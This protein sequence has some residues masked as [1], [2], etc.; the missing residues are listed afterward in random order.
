MDPS[1]NSQLHP[2]YRADADLPTGKVKQSAQ[3]KPIQ[4]PSKSSTN[5]L[6]HAVSEGRVSDE[7]SLDLEVFRTP[8]L[9]T[10]Q[11][12]NK[13]RIMPGGALPAAD[14]KASSQFKASLADSANVSKTNLVSHLSIMEPID[15]PD[16]V[17]IRAQ[18]K[19]K[20]PAVDSLKVDPRNAPLSKIDAKTKETA[21][22]ELE[23]ATTNPQNVNLARLR[24]ELRNGDLDRLNPAQQKEKLREA[25]SCLQGC[26]S[27]K[28]GKTHVHVEYMDPSNK[29]SSSEEI[30]TYKVA[31][32]IINLTT[33]P[34]ATEILKKDRT[35]SIDLCKASLQLGYKE[36]ID[37]SQEKK[38]FAQDHQA[39]LRHIFNSLQQNQAKELKKNVSDAELLKNL[40]MDVVPEKQSAV[41]AQIRESGSDLM[42]V[43]EGAEVF[44][45]Q[46][47]FNWWSNTI[48]ENLA[49]L[50]K[51]FQEPEKI[52]SRQIKKYEGLQQSEEK[53]LK[54]ANQPLKIMLKEASKKGGG[55]VAENL[56][57]FLETDN[58]SQRQ[59]SR[60]KLLGTYG[61]SSPK[62][63]EELKKIKE[64]LKSLNIDENKFKELL[65]KSEGIASNLAKG[66]GR[67][68]EI[69]KHFNDRNFPELVTV[70][71]AK[72]SF[73]IQSTSRKGH[74]LLQESISL[75]LKQKMA[76]PNF[77]QKNDLNKQIE[78][79]TTLMKVSEGEINF[80]EL[81]EFMH[82]LRRKGYLT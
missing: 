72:E 65:Q 71:F 20:H 46:T 22:K 5:S 45:A 75:Y 64:E 68:A 14:K 18:A 24:N 58:A 27:E 47:E 66:A 53:R 52:T 59:I 38:K 11:V 54:L 43:R 62:G 60:E 13:H 28:E 29:V 70:A 78:K 31:N 3:E 69:K 51:A 50:S 74:T 15:H 63:I 4:T 35:L 39:D 6:G 17:Q 36:V 56:K 42:L 2:A 33:K 19:E 37:R 80:K 67:I 81:S 9:S 34:W 76:D 79:F 12:K 21:K 61:T 44:P 41:A 48:N 49:V 10:D 32:L 1:S 25:L 7:T 40:N 8:A 26:V 23:S 16:I 55:T 73:D 77:T 82:G 30:P 57:V